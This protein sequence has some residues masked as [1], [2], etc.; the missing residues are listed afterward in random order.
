MSVPRNPFNMMNQTASIV[1]TI[2]GPDILTNTGLVHWFA[3]NQ[4]YRATNLATNFKFYRAAEVKWEYLPLYNTF[5]ENNSLAVV[6]KPYILTTMNRTQEY[7]WSSLPVVDQRLQILAQGAQ[8]TSFVGKKV[9]QY[10]PNWCSPG[11][12]AVT[13]EGG[14]GGA[15][16]GVTNLGLRTQYGYLACP[17][18]DSFIGPA[19][20]KP[21]T[22]GS[23]FPY[24]TVANYPGDVVYNG[25]YIFV[26]QE[27]S[28]PIP[29]A[30]VTCTV[31]WEFKEP[32]LA[33]RQ[34]AVSKEAPK[35]LSGNL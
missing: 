19:P 7:S 12:T 10:R 29:I 25:H 35:D 2:Q 30:S 33:Y 6:T 14:T 24:A 18:G 15:V 4:F 28:P 13:Y 16:T 34:S 27:N 32:N 21:V 8:P 31:R 3:L 1:E 23:L 5:Q 20:N 26:E 22:N 9:L 11:L 17:Q